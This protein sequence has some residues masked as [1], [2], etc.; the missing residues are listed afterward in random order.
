[1]PLNMIVNILILLSSVSLF[2]DLPLPITRLCGALHAFVLP[3][4]AVIR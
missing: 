3:G 1:M 2:A 4:Y